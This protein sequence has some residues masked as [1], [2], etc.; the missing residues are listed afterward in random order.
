MDEKGLEALRECKMPVMKIELNITPFGLNFYSG[1]CSHGLKF[2]ERETGVS[3]KEFES[4]YF[5]HF[6]KASDAFGK[7]LNNLINAKRKTLS[8]MI[9]SSKAR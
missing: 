2:L 8:V 9:N 7:E 3:C 6:K 4:L 1:T 5:K